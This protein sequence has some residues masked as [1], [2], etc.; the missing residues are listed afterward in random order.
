[1]ILSFKTKEKRRLRLKKSK[2]AE[3]VPL[4]HIRDRSLPAVREKLLLKSI[5]RDTA[6]KHSPKK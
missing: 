2:P 6:E 1:M 5:Q 3:G 4:S